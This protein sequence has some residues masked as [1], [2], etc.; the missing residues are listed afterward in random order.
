MWPLATTARNGL[1]VA[2]ETLVLKRSAEKYTDGVRIDDVQGQMVRVFDAETGKAVMEAPITPIYDGGGNVAIS[3]SGKR[4]A[5]LNGN[6][7]QVYE[8]PSADC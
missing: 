4:V 8:L 5:I 7:I 1:R 6:A 2:R 3:P